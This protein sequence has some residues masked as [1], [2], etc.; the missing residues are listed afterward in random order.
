MILQLDLET[1]KTLDE[2]RV[3][4]AGSAKGTTLAPSQKHAYCHLER[5]LRRS[6]Y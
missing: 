3:Y 6:A 1:H 4:L 2:L 5:V